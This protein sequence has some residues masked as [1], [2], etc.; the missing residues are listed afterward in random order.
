MNN[1]CEGNLIN[2]INKVNNEETLDEKNWEQ[3]FQN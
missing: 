3:D 2:Q 1:S